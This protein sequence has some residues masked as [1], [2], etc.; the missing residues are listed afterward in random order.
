M[1]NFAITSK[2]LKSE[3]KK[4]PTKRAKKSSISSCLKCLT[5]NHRQI[6]LFQN[7]HK[8][9]WA[10]KSAHSTVVQLVVPSGWVGPAPN[11]SHVASRRKWRTVSR[12]Q[13]PTRCQLHQQGGEASPHPLPAQLLTL[14]PLSYSH[15]T[16]SATHPLPAQLLTIQL[17]SAHLYLWFFTSS[18]TCSNLPT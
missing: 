4:L 7:L 17:L 12:S 15:F 8:F 2:P 6:L 13:Q 9:Y 16:R 11:V 10:L 3:R 5:F 14:Y 1:L 18:V